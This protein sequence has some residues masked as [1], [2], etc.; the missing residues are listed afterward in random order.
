MLNRLEDSRKDLLNPF[1]EQIRQKFLECLDASSR[2]GQIR[3]RIRIKKRPFSTSMFLRADVVLY[4]PR[5]AISNNK[6][7]VIQ[8]L[9]FVL[10]EREYL[11]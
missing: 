2:F 1:A 6:P 8:V 10:G 4:F 7:T 11:A 5:I 3:P 9:F